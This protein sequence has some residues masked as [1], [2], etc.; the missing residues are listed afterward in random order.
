MF[1]TFSFFSLNLFAA[2]GW[3]EQKAFK[4]VH[5][6]NIYD[7]IEQAHR[8]LFGLECKVSEFEENRN[9]LIANIS[10]FVSNASSGE[11]KFIDVPVSFANEDEAKTLFLSGL[12]DKESTKFRWAKCFTVF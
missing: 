10:F 3:V 6:N 2:I 5:E 4:F 1:V 9:I 7:D 12:P 8:K 11:K